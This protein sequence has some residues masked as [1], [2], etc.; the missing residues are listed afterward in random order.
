MK[1][2]MSLLAALLVLTA[3]AGCKDETEPEITR[4]NV[5][6]DCGVVPLSVEVYGAASGGDESG[7]PTGG[8]NNLEYRW[9]FGDGTAATSIAY[10]EY[11]TPGDYT[12]TLTVT[13][14]AG[15]TAKD[16]VMVSAIADSLTMSATMTPDTGIDVTTPVTFNFRAGSCAVD[17]D[18]DDDYVKLAPTWR[19][20]DP[21]FPDGVAV[22]Y[23]RTPTHTF[24]APG[25]YD[26]HLNVHFA[27]WAVFRNLTMQVTVDP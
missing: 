26:V 27:E 15:K 4:I 1:R 25:T 12:I 18:L 11:A 23:G 6:Q 13:D 24:S 20:T 17:P 16:E 10:H 3:F 9:D 14:P 5:S 22:Y 7:D 21:A 2:L 19:V 8:V